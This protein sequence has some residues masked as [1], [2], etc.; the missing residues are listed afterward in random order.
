MSDVRAA[1]FTQGTEDL[2]VLAVPW[3]CAWM[4]MVCAW[5]KGYVANMAGTVR[6]TIP[7]TPTVPPSSRTVLYERNVC[8]TGYPQYPQHQS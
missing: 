4:R 2:I 5:F 3:R 7:A 8:P 1:D 6:N